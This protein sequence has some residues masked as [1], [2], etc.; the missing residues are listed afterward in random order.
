MLPS[1]F[2]SEMGALIRSLSLKVN[3]EPSVKDSSPKDHLERAIIA[4]V[5]LYLSLEDD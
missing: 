4:L 5:S 1:E 3:T 2:Q